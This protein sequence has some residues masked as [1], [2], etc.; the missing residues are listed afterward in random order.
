M[1]FVLVVCSFEPRGWSIISGVIDEITKKTP[2]EIFRECFGEHKNINPE[3]Y[4][5]NFLFEIMSFLST[6]KKVFPDE[7]SP[8]LF[9]FCYLMR[10][11]ELKFFI[12]DKERLVNSLRDDIAHQEEKLEFLDGDTNFALCLTTQENQ[13]VENSISCRCDASMG[14]F[15]FSDRISTEEMGKGMVES[16][17]EKYSSK[18]LGEL[19]IFLGEYIPMMRNGKA[20]F[21]EKRFSNDLKSFQIS[22]GKSEVFIQKSRFEISLRKAI[23]EKLEC[24]C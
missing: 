1:H 10:D 7:A 18:V 9:E 15:E 20:K 4:T 24:D 12:G 5:H 17:S 8:V 23:G 16:W 21:I 22:V 2:D 3:I 19:R 13:V 14:L 11:R 6:A